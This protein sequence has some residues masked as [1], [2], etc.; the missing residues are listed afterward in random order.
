MKDKEAPS[1][2]LLVILA[3]LAGGMAWGI[4]G[5]FGHETGAMM[6]GILV[7]LVFVLA[8]G[9]TWTSL[10]G[11]RAVAMFALG[12]S[13]GGSMT[14]GQTI[15]L[16][17]LPDLVGN[18]EALRWGLLG[19]FIKGGIWIGMAAA[20]LAIAMSRTPYRAVELALVLMVMLFLM[21]LGVELLNRPFDPA[22]RQLPKIYFSASW[23][24]Q[25]DA[26]IKPR[27]E[28]W[29]GLLFAL[30]GLYVYAGFLRGDRLVRWLTLWGIV[31][32][33]L[34]FAG[35]QCIQAL[36]A[37]HPEVFHESWFAEWAPYVN[38]WNTMET[39]FGLV[40]GAVLAVGLWLNRRSIGPPDDFD[41][42]DTVE[43]SIAGEWLLVAIHVAAVVAWNFGSFDHLDAF[44]DL[45][46]TMVV[47]P[48]IAV[49]AGRLW[50]Y[51]L[52]LPIVTLP[53]AGKTLRELCY[54]T[55]EVPL[56]TGWLLYVAVPMAITT[57]AALLLAHRALKSGAISFAR[58]SLLITTW[59]FFTLNLAFFRYPWPWQEWTR[60]T[61]HALVYTVCAVA[62][63]LAAVVGYRIGWSRGQVGSDEESAPSSSN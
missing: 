10:F 29:G 15:G 58:W 51:L 52:T 19:L 41:A 50:P 23:H 54:D 56:A 47:I 60:R 2:V 46:L 16:T 22:E 17:Q 13:V 30:A 27:P 31:G 57:A 33:G 38:W 20:F 49:W 18:V 14:Y 62:L 34:G 7:G 24:W 42:A 21:F 28:N 12:V 39:T 3:A 4:R 44:A 55:S 45:A 48:A 1:L 37:W 11:A 36:H 25:P 6:A 53:I 32:G 26:D 5:Q 9:R 61:P 63:T 8:F 59:T 40:L 43:L 35:G